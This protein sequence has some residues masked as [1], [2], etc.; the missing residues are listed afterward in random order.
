[1]VSSRAFDA[2]IVATFFAFIVR[3]PIDRLVERSQA[4]NVF[5]TVDVRLMDANMNP[6]LWAP[7]TCNL[8]FRSDVVGNLKPIDEVRVFDHNGFT[9]DMQADLIAGQAGKNDTDM[10]VF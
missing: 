7:Y 9:I 6:T 8:Q 10:R 4:R 1:M 3:S 5:R 2:E